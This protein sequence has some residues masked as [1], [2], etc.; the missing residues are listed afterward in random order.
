M[1]KEQKIEQTIREGK[2]RAEV[3]YVLN[4]FAFEL[5]PES[6]V[7]R[8]TQIISLVRADER[9]WIIEETKKF[10][11]DERKKER[12]RILGEIEKLHWYKWDI[13]DFAGIDDIRKLLRPESDTEGK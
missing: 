5:S 12:E 4:T 10:Q 6:F 8:C 11:A 9:K 2:L 3:Y 1:T 7:K 13:P